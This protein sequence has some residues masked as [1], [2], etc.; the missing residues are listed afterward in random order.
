MAGSSHQVAFG[1]FMGIARR[2]SLMLSGCSSTT[3][4]IFGGE[5]KSEVFKY[6]LH[7]AFIVRMP[8]L[9]LR[10]S[11]TKP[12]IEMLRTRFPSSPGYLSAGQRNTPVFLAIS[13]PIWQ[14]VR[15]V[16]L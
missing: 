9:I 6:L 3:T 16:V 5:T 4:Q 7:P 2:P 15:F 13:G 12:F 10:T 8:S 11:P 1:P 14:A